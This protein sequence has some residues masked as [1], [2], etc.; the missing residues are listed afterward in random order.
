MS[1]FVTLLLLLFLNSLILALY[2]ESVLSYSLKYLLYDEFLFPTYNLSSFSNPEYLEYLSSNLEF[3]FAKSTL[4]LF[5]YLLKVSYSFVPFKS[6]IVSNLLTESI[7]LKFLI[8]PSCS[9]LTSFNSL[10][11]DDIWFCLACI[12]SELLVFLSISLAIEEYNFCISVFNLSCFFKLFKLSCL[13]CLAILSLFNLS[14]EL[15]ELVDLELLLLFKSSNLSKFLTTLEANFKFLPI[16]SL[17]IAP[18][19]SK[20]TK[21]LKSVE[22]ASNPALFIA[23]FISDK[24]AFNFSKYLFT[25]SSSTS[26]LSLVFFSISP[27][28]VFKSLTN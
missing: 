10:Y 24:D 26:K 14:L 17:Y 13:S 8:I 6:S 9:F 2:S 4:A 1:K 21:F 3:L 18:S 23:E 28:A 12:T 25:F 27:I 22:L 15:L 20:F 19:S 5:S 16:S 7:C 11:S